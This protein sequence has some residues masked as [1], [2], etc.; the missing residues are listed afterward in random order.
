VEIHL[1]TL[2]VPASSMGGLNVRH[3]GARPSRSCCADS[4]APPEECSSTLERARL[5]HAY[6]LTPWTRAVDSVPFQVLDRVN[7]SAVDCVICVTE[8]AVDAMRSQVANHLRMSAQG[9]SISAFGGAVNAV[10]S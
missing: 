3:S 9:R 5:L 6:F 10:R 2:V 1:I 4:P 7:I 8:S